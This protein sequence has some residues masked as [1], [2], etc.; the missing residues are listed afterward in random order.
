MNARILLTALLVACGGES[1]PDVAAPAADAPAKAP[2]AAPAAPE[3]E[4]LAAVEPGDAEAGAVIYKTYC[5]ACH[6]ADGTGM[7]GMLAA[8]FTEKGRLDKT[9]DQLRTSIRDGFQG[10]KAIMPPWKGTLT[11]QDMANALAHIRKTYQGK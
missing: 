1:T 5:E 4:P 11:D 10:E 7:G 2:E 6:Q 9:D 8:N 3:A